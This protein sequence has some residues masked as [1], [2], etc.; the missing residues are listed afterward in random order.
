L[1]APEKTRTLDQKGFEF[2]L[3][4]LPLCKCRGSELRVLGALNAQTKFASDR[5]WKARHGTIDETRH[6]CALAAQIDGYWQELK[7]KCPG[8]NLLG[9]D[10]E[11]G[12]EDLRRR[13]RRGRVAERR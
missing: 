9:E 1:P 5:G 13:A 10:V 6:E 8:S 3:A 12:G 2:A 7:A 11:Y 4:P